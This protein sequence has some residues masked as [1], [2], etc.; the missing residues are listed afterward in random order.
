MTGTLQPEELA[1][2]TAVDPSG[3]K[4]GTV[5]NVYL[6]DAT[7]APLWVTV[8]TGMFGNRQS[9]APLRGAHRDGDN[10]VLTVGKDITGLDAFGG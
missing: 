10:L 9:F 6:D 3:A 8:T 7:G 1:G 5:E 4:I 2:L